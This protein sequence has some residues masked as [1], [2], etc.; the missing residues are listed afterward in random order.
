MSFRGSRK[1]GD[2]RKSKIDLQRR[3]AKNRKDYKSWKRRDLKPKDS[4]N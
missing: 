1:R 4:P 3:L 2:K